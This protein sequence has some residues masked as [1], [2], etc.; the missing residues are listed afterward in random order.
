MYP[1]ELERIQ[2]ILPPLPTQKKI[3]AI[4]EKAEELKRLREEADKWTG[5]FLQSVFLEMFG[6]L[7]P[8]YYNWK[9]RSV[10]EL[11]VQKKGSM[12][13]GPFGSNL[14]HSE[15]VD[16]GIAVMG[17]DNAVNNHFQWD[18]R[19]FI[20]EEKY[21]ELKRYRVFPEDVLIT[22]MGTIGRTCVVPNDIPISISTKHLA[23][24]TCD[25]SKCHPQFLSSAFLYHP[26][27]KKQIIQ[28]NRGAIMAGLN[29]TIIKKVKFPIPPLSLQNKFAAIVE[30]VEQMK[31]AQVKSREE[32]DNL[33]NTLMQKAYKGELVT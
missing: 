20:T 24:L 15:F 23:V 2:L 10:K 5:E 19:R 12:R 32:I 22:I 7:N 14:L 21:Q 8:E 31:G 3:V 30:K 29:L 13:T 26:E 33:F 25:T 16:S 18:E 11:V 4:L 6:D 17:I 27:I 28:A 9:R 1:K